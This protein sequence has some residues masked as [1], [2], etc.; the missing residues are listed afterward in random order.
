MPAYLEV[1]LQT[2]LVLAL[3]DDGNASLQTPAEE[4]LSGANTVL[5]SDLLQSSIVPPSPVSI[6]EWAICSIVD[7]LLVAIVD[8]GELWVERVHLDLSVTN[9][10]SH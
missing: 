3:R 5:V 4:D 8:E 9:R 7:A 6:A 2:R 1:L 10:V